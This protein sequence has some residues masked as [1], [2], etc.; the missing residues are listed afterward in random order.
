MDN[1]FHWDRPRS[2]LMNPIFHLIMERYFF[3]YH[4]EKEK[5]LWVNSGQ[6]LGQGARRSCASVPTISEAAQLPSYVAS[7]LFIQNAVDLRFS[8][9]PVDCDVMM[10]ILI[11]YSPKLDVS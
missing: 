9:A 4:L 7:I 3:S 10:P 2:L 11:Y 8:T 1:L 6:Q 5:M